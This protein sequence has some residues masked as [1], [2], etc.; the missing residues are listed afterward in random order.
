[1]GTRGGGTVRLAASSRDGEIMTKIARAPR[2]LVSIVSE[3]AELCLGAL[4]VDALGVGRQRPSRCLGR[5]ARVVCE[6]AIAYAGGQ[7]PPSAHRVRGATNRMLRL[8]NG[9]GNGTARFCTA[10]ECRIA[11]RSPL[12][13]GTKYA[14]RKPPLLRRKC[15]GHARA[16]H[17]GS[18]LGQRQQRQGTHAAPRLDDDD[19]L[20][21]TSGCHD[22]GWCRNQE[23]IC[24]HVVCTGLDAV[25]VAPG[26]GH[27]VAYLTHSTPTRRASRPEP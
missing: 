5:S 13:S 18:P 15:L 12:S 20:Q 9:S 21:A 24:P 7:G 2:R 23:A 25:T 16:R 1:M 27:E 14:R 11:T 26:D 22:V 19:R 3:E 6:G 17:P 4:V 10:S 8:D